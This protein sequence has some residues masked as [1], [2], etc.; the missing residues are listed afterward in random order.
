M[1]CMNENKNSIDV[2]FLYF[3]IKNCYLQYKVCNIFIKTDSR[4]SI[5]HLQIAFPLRM[6]DSRCTRSYIII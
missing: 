6:S 3:I 2:L 1:S 5:T 4:R